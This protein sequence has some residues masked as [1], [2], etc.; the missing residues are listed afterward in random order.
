M[1]LTPDKLRAYAKQFEIA[2]YAPIAAKDCTVLA[3]A[4]DIADSCAVSDIETNCEGTNINPD[5]FP[6]W[7]VYDLNSVHEADKEFVENAVRYLDARGLL[8]RKEGEPNI[9]SFKDARS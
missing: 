7:W 6:F 2:P 5:T 3:M 8:V 1:S 9:V 4:L